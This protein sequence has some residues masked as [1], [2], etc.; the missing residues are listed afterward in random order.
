MLLD[1]RRS[2]Y[3]QIIIK[4]SPAIVLASDLPPIYQ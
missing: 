3:L 4:K 2:L 1:V